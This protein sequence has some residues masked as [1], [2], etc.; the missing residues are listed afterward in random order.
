MALFANNQPPPDAGA[1]RSRKAWAIKWRSEN[2]LD[3]KQEYL[4]GG[5]FD[6]DAAPPLLFDT[7]AAARQRQRDSYG[8]IHHRPDL[9]REPHGWLSPQVV[10][11]RVTVEEI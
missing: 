5:L 10:R 8:Y 2:L 3:G 7:R 9:H 1:R 11:V 6:P 4:V